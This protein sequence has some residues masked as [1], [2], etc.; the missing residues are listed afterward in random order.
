METMSA[1]SRRSLMT[2]TG[3]AVFVACVIFL[4]SLI[5]YAD[6]LDSEA[7]FCKSEL[8]RWADV[9]HLCE[10]EP[11]ICGEIT[12]KSRRLLD[13]CKERYAAA[14]ERKK[15]GNL[16]D[17]Q[18]KSIEQGF[19]QAN[20]EEKEREQKFREDKKN[21]VLY[22]SAAVCNF[23]S[24]VLSKT[25]DPVLSEV[26]IAES[27]ARNAAKTMGVTLK[28]CTRPEVKKISACML[29]GERPAECGK[30]EDYVNAALEYRLR[31]SDKDKSSAPQGPEISVPKAPNL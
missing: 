26:T 29:E 8:D 22:L 25:E 19:R 13:D 21:A 30:L 6:P 11:K 10:Q 15:K 28:K 20:R 7:E 5:G 18:E 27:R 4:S 2:R 16:D 12:R 1:Q 24:L 14:I 9:P 17:N 31:L 23:H 3:V